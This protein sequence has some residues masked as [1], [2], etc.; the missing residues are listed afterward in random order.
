MFKFALEVSPQSLTIYTAKGEHLTVD[1]PPDLVKH[2]EVL[3]AQRFDKFLTSFIT[4]YK[5]NKQNILILLSDKLVF[6]KGFS[7]EELKT[8]PEVEDKFLEKIP[9][10]YR[11]IVKFNLAVQDRIFIFATNK[12]L[13]QTIRDTI[14]KAGGQVEAVIPMIPVISSH[15]QP[16]EKEDISK[17]IA[18]EKTFSNFDFTK[19]EAV[20]EFVVPQSEDLNQ[21]SEEVGNKPV[22]S[23]TMLIVGIV[24]IWI[25]LGLVVFKAQ[26]LQDFIKSKFSPSSVITPTPEVLPQ[27]SPTISAEVITS[28]S[29]ARTSPNSIGASSSAS[30]T[31]LPSNQLHFEVLNG[32]GIA[33]QSAKVE[34][35]LEPLGFTN[36]EL[37]NLDRTNKDIT[38]VNFSAKVDSSDQQKIIDSLSQQFVNVAKD[39]TIDLKDF[40]VVIIT[41][42][43]K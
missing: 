24:L 16:L 5:L 22:S 20:K 11:K 26:T 30:L 12:E 10:D 41:G 33:K 15:H 18:S 39:S 21:G 14:E 42:S 4:R 37:G 25:S 13:F 1:I 27:I 40:E 43:P 28:S 23:H 38:L 8:D 3:D 29:S 34:S 36:F 17:I 35:Q 7:Q 2:Q 32:T 6:Y 19:A 9:F 31:P